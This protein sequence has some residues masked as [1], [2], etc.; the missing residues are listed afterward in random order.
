MKKK[1]EIKLNFNRQLC[2]KLK[3]TQ[4]MLRT[5]FVYKNG[6][7]TT[8]HGEETNVHLR[9]DE[10][11]TLN[12]GTTLALICDLGINY[13]DYGLFSSEVVVQPLCIQQ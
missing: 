8:S 10:T 1:L 3:L 7:W 4:G 6:E 5:G 13:G 12:E 11:L 9:S 2:K